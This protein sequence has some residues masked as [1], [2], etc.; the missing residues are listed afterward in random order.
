MQVKLSNLLYLIIGLILFQFC[1]TRNRSAGQTV[2]IKAPTRDST[3]F[4][5]YMHG[6]PLN[7]RKIILN[8]NGTYEMDFFCDIFPKF[9][10]HGCWRSSDDT[11]FLLP[12]RQVA[13]KFELKDTM[14]YSYLY[15]MFGSGPDS[16]QSD[17]LYKWTVKEEKYLGYFKQ[18][19][20]V[21]RMVEFILE[22]ESQWIK[23]DN[24]PYRRI[25][26]NE[27]K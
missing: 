14:V 11:L 17:T 22:Q 12:Q 20:S 27:N 19:D 3:F 1:S 7:H 21:T 6:R 24:L 15:D 13:E 9:T 8:A 18:T 25:T 4:G 16:L 2:L 10:R 26:P 5:N 23:M